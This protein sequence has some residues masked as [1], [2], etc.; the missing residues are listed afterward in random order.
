MK[1]TLERKQRTNTISATRHFDNVHNNSNL[2]KFD[3][4]NYEGASIKR[5]NIMS[6]K[7]YTLDNYTFTNAALSGSVFN[8]IRFKDCNFSGTSAEFCD[9]YDCKFINT[10]QFNNFVSMNFG[11]SNFIN[12]QFNKVGIHIS[13][14]TNSLFKN[15]MFNNCKIKQAT[16]ESSVFDNVR[17][18]NMNLRNLNMEFCELK[19][20]YCDNVVFQISQ[21]SY[22][23]GGL[24]YVLNTNDKIWI[25]SSVN[26]KISVNEF[27]KL[28]PELIDYYKS[29]GE[30]FPAANLYISTHKYSKALDMINKGLKI[31]GEKRDFRML[32]FYCKLLVFNGWSN[33]HE[34]YT[35][36]EY[37]CRM[38]HEVGMSASEIHN[39]YINFGDLRKILLYNEYEM[40]ALYY[41]INSNINDSDF[42][43][44]AK[45]LQNIDDIIS[46][47]DG[48]T[49]SHYIEVRHSSPF[50]LLIVVTASIYIVKQICSILNDICSTVG[51]IEDNIIKAQDIKKNK[52]EIELNKQQIELNNQTME[53]N[54]AKIN[55]AKKNLNESKIILSGNSYF[56]NIG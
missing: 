18:I 51:N 12:C 14:L 42:N 19:N 7:I 29:M 5:S 37:L 28:I 9:L 11:N 48:E 52:Q 20:I 35:A 33:K 22:I 53:I 8:N 45:L 47:F 40:P 13:T 15:C 39:Y 6:D 43:K 34:R 24:E 10:K 54:K 44:F 17:F 23:F 31:S 3:R 27:K 32:K 2:T 55:E 49:S 26:N 41:S 1:V 30:F 4:K 50:S 16:F 56:K 36:Y 25:S 21:I 38:D 46:D